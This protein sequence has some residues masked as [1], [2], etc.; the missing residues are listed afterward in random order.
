MGERDAARLGEQ[1]LPPAPLEQLVT[2][3]ILELLDLDRQG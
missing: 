2:E 3:L 1:Q